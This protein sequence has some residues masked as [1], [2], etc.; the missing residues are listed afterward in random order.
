MGF[1]PSRERGLALKSYLRA[2]LLNLRTH[3]VSKRVHTLRNGIGSNR[4]VIM[5]RFLI[6]LRMPTEFGQR[7]RT[8]AG[9][10]AVKV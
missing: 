7:K 1:Y 4:R 5:P 6:P 9:R 3:F 8:G 2:L 10:S